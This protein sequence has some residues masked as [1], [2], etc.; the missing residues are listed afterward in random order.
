MRLPIVA[1]AI[2][3]TGMLAGWLWIVGNIHKPESGIEPLGALLSSLDPSQIS[4]SGPRFDASQG[5]IDVEPP[6]LGR[7]LA[8]A[9][10]APDVSTK[11]RFGH[12]YAVQAKRE[13]G[14]ATNHPRIFWMIT[15]PG[16]DGKLGTADDVSI[17]YRSNEKRAGSGSAAR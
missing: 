12:P 15:D 9:G 16:S 14:A 3:I 11:N 6:V 8:M 5:W 2:L 4:A 13:V 1:L 17:G 7:L 10:A